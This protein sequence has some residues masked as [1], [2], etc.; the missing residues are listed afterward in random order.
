MAA[1]PRADLSA[2]GRF[3]PLYH[4][5]EPLKVPED[6][7]GRAHCL[8]SSRGSEEDPMHASHDVHCMI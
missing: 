8:W 7:T 3:E 5:N 2:T 6:A 4:P 1:G